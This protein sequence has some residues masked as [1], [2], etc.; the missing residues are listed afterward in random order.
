MTVVN[1]IKPVFRRTLIN[2]NQSFILLYISC[3]TGLCCVG[4]D[5]GP[6]RHPFANKIIIENAVGRA[7]LFATRVSFQRQCDI[8]VNIKKII[9]RIF[10][11]EY[12]QNR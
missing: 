1:G 5:E 12:L 3:R 9:R 11:L 2:Q 8:T 10:S 4:G 6:C 7:R